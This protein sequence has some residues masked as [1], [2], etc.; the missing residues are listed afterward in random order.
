M[1][2]SGSTFHCAVT[3][4]GRAGHR[5]ACE[6]AGTAVDLQIPF[7]V[8]KSEQRSGPKTRGDVQS[9]IRKVNLTYVHPP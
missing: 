6:V 2:V 1:A 3:A 8:W 4:G 7:S 9:H 5:F